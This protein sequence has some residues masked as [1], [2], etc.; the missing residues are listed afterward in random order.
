MTHDGLFGGE[1]GA[2]RHIGGLGTDTAQQG[3]QGAPSFHGESFKLCEARR[4]LGENSSPAD[5]ES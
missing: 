3:Q 4:K 1:L 5:G 2:G